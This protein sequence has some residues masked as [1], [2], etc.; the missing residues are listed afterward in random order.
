MCIATAVTAMLAY[1]Y[2]VDACNEAA[3]APRVSLCMLIKCCECDMSDKKN[4]TCCRACQVC[5]AKLYTECC[6]CVGLCPAPD[7]EDGL[8]KTSSIE[9]LPDPIPDLF[10][11]LTEEEDTLQRWTTHSYS[12][13]L[14]SLLFKPGTG[15]TPEFD[16]ITTDQG[17]EKTGAENKLELP[18]EAL[19]KYGGLMGVQNCTVAFFSQCMSIGKCKVSCKSM[20]AAK[21]RWFHEYGCCQCI[22]NT[23][24]DYGLSE[25]QCLRCPAGLG[26]GVED[27]STSSDLSLETEDYIIDSTNDLKLGEDLDSLKRG[28]DI[29]PD[30][31]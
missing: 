15:Y 24:L 9:N 16:A 29:V 5:L 14:D 25:P 10:T 26:T 30:T 11:V 4:C 7:P 12:Y 6:S 13:S 8:Y 27:D 2:V 3:C 17:E 28:A 20:G 19:E 21:Y 31:V 23:C 1:L 18:Q 22:G